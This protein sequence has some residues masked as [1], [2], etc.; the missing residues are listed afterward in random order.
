MKTSMGRSASCA[1]AVAATLVAASGAQAA[2]LL[3]GDFE[4]NPP[5]LN[6]SGFA[7]ANPDSW[8]FTSGGVSSTAVIYGAG[9]GGQPFVDTRAL[10]LE[11]PGD[12][13]S[14]SVT[15]QA[16]Q[17]YQLDF[18]VAA[19]S[20]TGYVLGV[21][22]SNASVGGGNFSGSNQA[23]QTGSILFT[24]DGGASTFS[25]R[26]DGALFSYPQLDNVSVT[27]VPEVQE[28]AMMLAGLGLVGWVAR[29][30]TGDRT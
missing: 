14:Q 15:L 9:Y 21:D 13:I 11:R 18:L 28:W 4:T 7:Y 8:T 2:L 30:R 1:L 17:Q 25:F 22:I 10:Q 6:V 27:A 5:V 3:N 16:G 19:Y 20:P 23:F 12:K 26:S 29:R 24:A